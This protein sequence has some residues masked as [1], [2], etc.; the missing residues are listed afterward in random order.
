MN[1]P[2]REELVTEIISQFSQSFATART[3]W[4]RFAEE[5]HPELRAP[6]MMLLQT[7][8]RRGPIT[9]TGLGSLLDMDKAVV[10]RQIAK[11]RSLGLV[12]AREAES[13]R[14]VML[15]TASEAAHTAMESMQARTSADYLA[16]FTGWSDSEL[17]QFQSLL[18]R[19]NAAAEDPRS[20]GPARRCA[21]EEHSEGNES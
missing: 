13:D 21:R 18:Q 17:A 16:R 20:D 19:F 1:D 2:T 9:A 6:G 7:I 12:H 10:S 14:R 15:L 5:V 4:T 11:L 3:R 8:I